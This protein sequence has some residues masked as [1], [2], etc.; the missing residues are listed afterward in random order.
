MR[1]LEFDYFVSIR[2]EATNDTLSKTSH[3]PPCVCAEAGMRYAPIQLLSNQ[4]AN[5]TNMA[6]LRLVG[7]VPGLVVS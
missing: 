2:T 1:A 5:T 7:Q 3:H 6:P 4:P